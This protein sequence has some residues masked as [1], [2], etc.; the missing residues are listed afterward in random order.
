LGKARRDLGLSVTFTE[1]ERERMARAE[2]GSPQ[3]LKSFVSPSLTTTR[4]THFDFSSP[5]ESKNKRKKSD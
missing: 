5:E 4:S 3:V 1:F 2:A